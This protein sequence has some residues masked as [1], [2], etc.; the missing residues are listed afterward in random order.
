MNHDE[1]EWLLILDIFVFSVDLYLLMLV[2]FQNRLF[3]RKGVTS[4]NMPTL[5]RSKG[6]H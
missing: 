3:K 1:N 4:W 2:R 5:E 6:Y